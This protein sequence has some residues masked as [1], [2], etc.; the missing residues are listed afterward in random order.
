MKLSSYLSFQG[1]MSLAGQ[2]MILKKKANI[3]ELII[4]TRISCK[5]NIKHLD[6]SLEDWL[7]LP[8]AVVNRSARHNGGQESFWRVENLSQSYLVSG[9]CLSVSQYIE[10]QPHWLSRILETP[11]KTPSLS[12]PVA[13]FFDSLR[14]E[15]YI[16][17][18]FQHRL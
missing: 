6:N 10:R 17:T 1:W 13:S 15:L 2:D 18:S 5:C 16:F 11:E 8:N 14:M 7:I 9:W 12:P 3:S 4:L